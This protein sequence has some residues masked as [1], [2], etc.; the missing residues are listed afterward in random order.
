MSTS[1]VGCSWAEKGALG[2]WERGTVPGAWEPLTITAEHSC[3]LSAYPLPKERFEYL[4]C[5]DP[6]CMVDNIVD[7]QILRRVVAPQES[8]VK[9]TRDTVG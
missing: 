4:S 1:I 7:T 5:T 6:G 2:I 3:T 9:N 8:R